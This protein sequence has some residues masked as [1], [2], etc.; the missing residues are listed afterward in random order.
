MNSSVQRLDPAWTIV[1][2]LDTVI[3]SLTALA[4]VGIGLLLPGIT[5]DYD[6]SM[7]D[8]MPFFA[9]AAF[10]LVSL[11]VTASVLR[12]RFEGQTSDKAV[13][14]CLSLSAVR[15]GLIVCGFLAYVVYG[16]LTYGF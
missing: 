8:G 12:N 5:E 3:T 1:L 16:A 4:S 13:R 10:L 6:M 14:L 11:A 2:A 9:L 15:L 7:A